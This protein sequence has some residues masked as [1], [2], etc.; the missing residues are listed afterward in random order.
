MDLE[1]EIKNI[2]SKNK[3]DLRLDIFLNKLLFEKNGYYY[4]NRVLGA[5]KDFIT[6]PEISQIFGEIV[7][8][9]LFFFWSEKIFSRFNLI[10]LG[11]GNGTLFNDISNVL[12][13]YPNFFSNANINFIEINKALIKLQKKNIRNDFSQKI[14]WRN[15]INFKSK[16]PSIIYS[17]E[18]F[19]CFP[20]R[21]FIFDEVWYEKYV[22]VNFTENKL[23]I[24]KKKVKNKEL[25]LLLEKYK[26]Q[27]ILEISFN[28]NKY[29]EEICN[30][31]KKRRGLIFTID[32]GYTENITNFTLQA[33]Q[34]HKYSHILENIGKK[35]ISSHV[36]FKDLIDIAKSYKL[37]IEEF[38]S[39]RD[40][41]LKYGIIERKKILSKSSNN[42]FENEVDRLINKNQMG[43]LFK[44]LVV[45][46][47]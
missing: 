28:R 39:Q 8:L 21:H 40:F 10:E 42:D 2:I 23:F 14:T 15:K 12:I 22:S 7:G 25:N 13:K 19:D 43:N 35:D 9:Y 37:K 11:P 5:K 17:N 29:F 44:C 26:K 36:N 46:N 1:K 18:F 27:K 41:L 30:L 32:Y 6:S 3:R 33:V 45:T 4:N 47:L 38:S 16:L 24:K 31:I 34:N 20:V